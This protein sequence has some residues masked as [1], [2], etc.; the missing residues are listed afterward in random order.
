MYSSVAG[1][2][3]IDSIDGGAGDDYISASGMGTVAHGGEGNDVLTSK[4]GLYLKVS[5]VT[6]ATE[7]PN[8]DI[9]I[10]DHRALTRDEVWSDFYPLMN[11]SVSSAQLGD[12]TVYTSHN[13]AFVGFTED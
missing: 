13:G 11:F 3:G 10:N 7:P 6:E 12:H 8:A 9:N 4:T 2:T 5:W 1:M